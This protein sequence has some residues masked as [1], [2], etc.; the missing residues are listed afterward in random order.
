[1]PLPVRPSSV[2]SCRR[3]QLVKVL[4]CPLHRPQEASGLLKAISSSGVERPLRHPPTW[5]YPDAP[6]PISARSW[7]LRSGDIDDR[8]P[9]RGDGARHV[10]RRQLA[11]VLLGFTPCGVLEPAALPGG[12]V[13]QAASS[14]PRHPHPRRGGNRSVK[15]DHRSPCFSTCSGSPIWRNLRPK[16]A[17]SARISPKLRALGEDGGLLNGAYKQ[18]V[19]GSSPAVP[20]WIKRC[21]TSVYV[22][23]PSAS[24]VRGL[25]VSV[26]V[27]GRRSGRSETSGAR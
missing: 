13:S 4:L 2:V 22:D 24:P 11:E 16:F 23:P 12:L 5:S 8:L 18:G 27:R 19:A 26:H 17:K 9:I 6:L 21:N 3:P 15:R 10:E 1:M 20:I 7:R 14:N 25:H